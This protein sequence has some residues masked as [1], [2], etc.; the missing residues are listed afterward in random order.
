MSLYANYLTEKTNRK[1]KENEFGYATYSYSEDA[2]YIEDIYVLP[3]QRHNGH[4]KLLA[5]Q[6]V[7]EAKAKGIKKV[8]GS[9]VCSIKNSTDGIT[10]LLKYGMKL[11]SSTNNFILFSKEIL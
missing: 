8:Y 10:A 9:V 2:V 4:A 7:E 1:I 11:D 5:D 3:E 6:I